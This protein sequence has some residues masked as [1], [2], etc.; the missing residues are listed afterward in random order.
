[1][2]T[3]VT[4]D[5]FREYFCPNNFS[6]EGLRLLFDYLERLE[7]DTD[8]EI[9]FDVIAICCDYSEQSFEDFAFSYDVEPI[10][11]RLRKS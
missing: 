3:T 11:R 9:E 6:C 10:A 2:K 5:K 7:E 8:T 4:F 1:M